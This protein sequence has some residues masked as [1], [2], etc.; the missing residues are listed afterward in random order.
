MFFTQ[1]EEWH[2]GN[3]DTKQGSD[4]CRWA[5]AKKTQYKNSIFLK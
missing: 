1:S 3:F 2:S 4:L 5:C